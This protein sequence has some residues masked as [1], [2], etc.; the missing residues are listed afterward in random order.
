MINYNRAISTND[1]LWRW[2]WK[3]WKLSL[4]FFTYMAKCFCNDSYFDSLSDDLHDVKTYDDTLAVVVIRIL[5]RSHPKEIEIKKLNSKTSPEF[6][7]FSLLFRNNAVH[8]PFAI[9]RRV[10]WFQQLWCALHWMVV[11]NERLFHKFR[12]LD[13]ACSVQSAHKVLEIFHHHQHRIYCLATESWR[14]LLCRRCEQIVQNRLVYFVIRALKTNHFC[15]VPI[16]VFPLLFQINCRETTCCLN[17]EKKQH[18][19]SGKHFISFQFDAKKNLNWRKMQMKLQNI[20][21]NKMN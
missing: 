2:T 1:Y 19:K 3:S 6:F 14:A 5:P 7:K 10:H 4:R 16:L 13:F 12:P 8:F 20:Y 18:K 11:S 15:R 9:V 17:R 21:S